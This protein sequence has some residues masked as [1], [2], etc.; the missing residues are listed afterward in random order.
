M[1]FDLQGNPINYRYIE[2]NPAFEKMTGLSKDKLLGRTVLEVMPDTES[3]WIRNFGEVVTS[4]KSR[5][6][7]NY[8]K[9]IGRWYKVVAYR[10]EPG[11]FAV[12]VEDITTRK[13]TEAA[14]EESE[15]RFRSAF[16]NAAHGMALVSTEGRFIKVNSALCDMLGYDEADLLSIDFQTISHPDDLSTDL[17]HVQELLQGK[18]ETYQLEKRYFH[19][20]G[21]IVWVLL[22]VSLV[23]T[24]DGIPI[25]FVS[26]I[27]DIT[28]VK[29]D[30]Q[31]L[32]LLL[33]EQKA[34]LENELVGIA[35]VNNRIITWANPA[36]EKML[37]YA[38]GELVG[39]SAR[40]N[41]L[42]E[43]AYISFGLN[44]YSDITTGKIH[45][46]QLEYVGKDGRQIW[47]DISGAMLDTKNGDSLWTI[48]DISEIKRIET[49]RSKYQEIE[50]FFHGIDQQ[51][52]KG[53]RLEQIF[54]YISEGVTR[55][56]DLQYAWV[57]RKEANGVV[58]FRAGA[59]P[60][61]KYRE[62]LQ[63]IGVRWDDT[64][65]GRGGTGTTIR[66]G[67]MLGVY[68]LS[69]SDFKPWSDAANRNNLAASLSLP[70]I[71]KGEVYG[72]F[73][74][75]SRHEHGFD[76]HE[77]LQ[78]LS[79]IT[80]R[81]CLAVETAT[82]QQQLMLLSSALSTTGH[83]VF[84][85]DQSGNIQWVNKAFTALTGYSEA[86]V[87]G[88]TPHILNS[89]N[90]DA[91]FFENLWQTI[92]KGEVWHGEMESRRKVGSTFFVRQTITPIYENEKIS[93]FIA[94][95]EDISA[96]KEAEARIEH[97]AHYDLLTN[98][99]NR[100]LFNNLLHQVLQL[101][102]RDSRTVALMFLDL[103]R[104][105]SVNDTLGH[106]AGDLLLQQVA[107]RLRESVRDSDTVAR[108]GGDEFTV[109]LPVITKM[110]DAA[111]VA[112]KIIAAFVTPF[113]LDGHMV[114]SST[115]IGI[116]IFPGDAIDEE[117]I[118]K[119]A[120]EAMY[121]AKESG[122][123]LFRFYNP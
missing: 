63:R 91:A 88:M 5:T 100:A 123:N 84:I 116:A 59:G 109:L 38:S 30:Q 42:N 51:I 6:F 121:K 15:L 37:G 69:Y 10:P 20:A 118:L 94:I 52:L 39:K 57:G 61:N 40:Q 50:Q 87:L 71:L 2:V 108:L 114:T 92:L 85:T 17:H 76:E 27:Q 90:Q 117:G 25:H 64:P 45:R 12:T 4:G 77:V 56:F 29:L 16:Q 7:D 105:K 110:E 19:K 41:Y 21:R 28:Q 9:E 119:M 65:L 86:E 115:S 73:T 44:A 67:R 31:H 81:I 106:H 104:F 112:E 18:I 24:K 103:D 111:N 102:K 58:S 82:D 1:I 83:G 13:Q 79:D 55:I 95:L 60:G 43:E 8:A 3:Y 96:E 32:D 120:D 35:K 23:R 74:L 99:P 68:K 53:Q 66:N 107:S 72:A 62:D 11:K 70:I 97:M 122:R 113:D 98:L 54:E 22:S 80:N 14:L 101:A 78:R 34:M 93:Y 89:D 36:F 49:D 46:S 48:L 33:S 75:Y 26:Q 47:V